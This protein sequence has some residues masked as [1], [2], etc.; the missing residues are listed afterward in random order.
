MSDEAAWPALMSAAQDGDAQSYRLLL[1]Q[2]IPVIRLLV[3]RRIF[4]PVL[5]D[6]VIQ[7]VLLTVHRV[8]H[9]YDPSCPFIPWIS[10]IATARSIDALRRRGRI[11]RREVRDELA[12]ESQADDLASRRV[13]GIA[14]EGELGQLLDLLPARQR[15]VVELVK[16][17]EMSLG[18]A[19]QASQLSVSAI[20]SL[21]HRALGRLRSLREN[22]P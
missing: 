2:I 10:A 17:H 15:Q 7:D 8:R 13:E 21:L 16:L 3:R 5:V 12:L 4:D 22:R 14:A 20:K 18:E 9:T 11:W 19:A 1:H 6:D